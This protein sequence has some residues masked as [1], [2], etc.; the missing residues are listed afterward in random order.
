MY[1]V[2]ALRAH[3]TYST[4]FFCDCPFFRAAKLGLIQ[5]ADRAFWRARAS[6]SKARRN[7]VLL[8]ALIALT[9]IAATG[10]AQEPHRAGLVVRFPDGRVETVCVEFS[11]DKITGGDLLNRSGLTVLFDFSTGLGAKVCKIGETGCDYP[12]EDCWCQCQGSPCNYWNYWQ[13]R[14]G[15]WVYSPLGASIRHLVDGEVDG[16]VWGDGQTPPPLLSLDDICQVQVETSASAL[17][18]PT[19]TSSVSPLAPPTATSPVSPLPSPAATTQRPVAP[20]STPAA[21]V[22]IPDMAGR[23]P[24]QQASENNPP[25]QADYYVGLAGVLAALGLIA[26]TTWR[27]RRGV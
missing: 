18:T 10:Q 22:F 20:P 12:R 23:S 26:L 4:L 6:S 14:N 1:V 19:A 13:L 24:T 8:I 15:N 17:N 27:R 25:V 3:T 5:P 16:W 2:C 21:Q 7:K 11:E 9:L